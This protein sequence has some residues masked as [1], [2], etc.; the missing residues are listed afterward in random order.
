MTTKQALIKKTALSEYTNVRK[1]GLQGI[2]LNED[3]ELI[4]VRLTDGE[5]DIVL[6]TKNGISLLDYAQNLVEVN[7]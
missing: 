3:D 1:S 2:N 5:N 6:V 4:D 7:G